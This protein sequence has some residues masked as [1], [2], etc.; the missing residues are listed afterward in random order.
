VL[1]VGPI[2]REP[3][4]VLLSLQSSCGATARGHGTD[5]FGDSLLEVVELDNVHFY[6]TVEEQSIVQ[7]RSVCVSLILVIL[8]MECI[9]KRLLALG[10]QEVFLCLVWQ[11]S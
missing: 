8:V 11:A 5:Y 6:V 10:V 1:P 3:A 7:N 9:S 2:G 4:F